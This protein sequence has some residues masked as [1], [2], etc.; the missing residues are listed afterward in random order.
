MRL[1]NPRT[2]KI[3]EIGSLRSFF[4]AYYWG[5]FFWMYKGV[6]KH[7]FIHMVVFAP[8]VYFLYLGYFQQSKA[9]ALWESFFLFKYIL[10]FLMCVH[11]VYPF[12]GR[13]IIKNHFLKRG[14]QEVN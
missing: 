5:P 8:L 3:I 2:N 6:W 10:V 13:K 7:F 1:K 4:G 11:V 9:E 12:F 14:W